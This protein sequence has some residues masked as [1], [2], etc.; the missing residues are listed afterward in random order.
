MCLLFNRIS[1]MYLLFYLLSR[2]PLKAG[3]KWA[4]VRPLW[5]FAGVIGLAVLLSAIQLLP[6]AEL[7]STVRGQGMCPLRDQSLLVR[8]IFESCLAVGAE[9][10]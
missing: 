7:S 5:S 1:H 4:D 8:F 9:L 10:P 2:R 6:A 3:V